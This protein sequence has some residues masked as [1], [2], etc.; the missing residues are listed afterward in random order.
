M[1]GWGGRKGKGP[2]GGCNGSK[3]MAEERGRTWFPKNCGRKRVAIGLT[4]MGEGRGTNKVCVTGIKSTFPLTYNLNYYF[5]QCLC[6][7]IFFFLSLNL[8]FVSYLAPYSSIQLP[9]P[10]SSSLLLYPAPYSFIQLPTP[11]PSSLLLCLAPYSSTQL[12]TPL[13]SSLLLYLAPCSFTQLPTPLPSALL[14]YQAPYTLPTSLPSS[15]LL[16]LAPYS[17]N[18]FLPPWKGPETEPETMDGSEGGVGRVGGRG[19]GE[20]YW[21][22]EEIDR[23]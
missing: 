12:S 23:I 15:L 18:L 17:S 7:S 4:L 11:L 20:G 8:F 16:Y 6:S 19:E 3:F 10:L 22:G 9:T 1:V 2:G 21:G 5:Q 13:P 14:L